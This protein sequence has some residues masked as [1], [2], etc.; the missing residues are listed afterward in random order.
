MPPRGIYGQVAT[1]I[2]VPCQNPNGLPEKL[3][4]LQRIRLKV[5]RSVWLTVR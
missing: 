2:S 5:L 1:L 3:L 4:L